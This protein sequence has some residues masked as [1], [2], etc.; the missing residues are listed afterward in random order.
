M[1]WMTQGFFCIQHLVR[2]EAKGSL[3]Q[4]WVVMSPK[5]LYQGWVVTES[6]SDPSFQLLFSVP[7]RVPPFVRGL[8][9]THTVDPTARCWEKCHSR[10]GVS[11]FPKERFSRNLLHTVSPPY[12]I[13]SLLRNSCSSLWC[14]KFREWPFLCVDQSSLGKKQKSVNGEV[15]R[16]FPKRSE[17]WSQ[18]I[19]NWRPFISN[20]KVSPLLPSSSAILKL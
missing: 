2:G 5:A 9:V 4:G 6:W 12:S 13:S 15:S 19:F 11:P 10:R 20:L 14:L 8:C 3:Y 17:G 7:P 16:L 18:S 1:C